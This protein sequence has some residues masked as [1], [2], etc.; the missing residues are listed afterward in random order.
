M[1]ALWIRQH[2]WQIDRQSYLAK[3]SCIPYPKMSRPNANG[4]MLGHVPSCGYLSRAWQ[5]KE[6]DT[7]HSH[8]AYVAYAVQDMQRIS[9]STKATRSLHRP[10]LTTMLTR[11]LVLHWSLC[12]V[13]RMT[14]GITTRDGVG[15]TSPRLHALYS[16]VLESAH[17][18]LSASC[19]TG[20]V[21]GLGPST[22]IPQTTSDHLRPYLRP[23]PDRS[24][25]LG[26][27]VHRVRPWR[28]GAPRPQHAS[29]SATCTL[30]GPCWVRM[31]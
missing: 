5:W 23:P 30:S 9:V 6:K 27:S 16:I 17:K 20:T 19:L 24:S 29:I 14:M 25:A 28:C 12:L 10:V 7:V 15:T 26:C 31:D 2:F 4:R 1:T 22:G 8:G 21:T 13:C 3:R 18:R 11:R